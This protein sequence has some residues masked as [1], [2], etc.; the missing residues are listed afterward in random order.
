MYSCNFVRQ[1]HGRMY[2]NGDTMTCNVVNCYLPC[3]NLFQSESYFSNQDRGDL[4]GLKIDLPYGM[5]CT[6]GHTY[7]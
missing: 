4:A 7:F 2:F 1:N 6:R 5:L 3:I